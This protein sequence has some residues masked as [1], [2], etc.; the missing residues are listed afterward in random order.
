M[1]LRLSSLNFRWQFS[2]QRDHMWYQEHTHAT[3]SYRSTL[4]LSNYWQQ[5]V[6]MEKLAENDLTYFY[7][8]HVVIVVTAVTTIS[9]PPVTVVDPG[10]LI[11]TKF[12]YIIE[13]ALIRNANWIFLYIVCVCA[14]FFSLFF[15]LHFFHNQNI[16]YTVTFITTSVLYKM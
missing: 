12:F 11:S 3:K 15:V 1:E 2:W 9:L 13:L 7:L 4:R 6:R 14:Y 5:H 10:S 8:H 16:L